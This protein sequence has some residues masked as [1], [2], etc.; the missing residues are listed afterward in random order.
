MSATFSQTLRS[1]ATERRRPSMGGIAL[2]V[3]LLGAWAFWFFRARVTVI[4][5]SETARL[6][7]DLAA[8]AVDAPVAGRIASS[9]LSIGLVV[10]TGDVLL[11]LD[12]EPEKRRLQE[13][14]TRLATIAPRIAAL[15]RVLAAEEQAIANDR[16]ATVIALGQARARR[17]EAEIAKRITTDEAERAA[18]LQ[19]SGAIAELE[20]LQ[21]EGEAERQRAAAQAMSLDVDLQQGNQKTRESQ[22]RA[23]IED[24]RV[25]LAA[26]E[27][28]AATETATIDRLRYE[29]DRRIIRAA[30]GGRIGDVAALR[31]GAYVKEGDKLGAIV[32]SGDIKIVAEFLPVAAMGRI[33][34]GQSARVRLDGYPWVEYGTLGA[35]VTG[36]GSELRAGR[37]RVELAVRPDRSSALPLEHGLPASAEVEVERV[38]PAALVARAVGKTLTERA[39]SS[40]TPSLP[41]DRRE[42]SP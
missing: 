13:E 1:L 12:S 19:A 7:V 20:A 9:R 28:Q 4:E 15:Q 2:T 27:G 3:I 32:P 36:V 11:E 38:T 33:R 21:K 8:H 39:T 37:I 31:P 6:E 35:T 42:A 23:R 22:A 10:A 16:G 25:E 26:L 24:M 18:K 30:I 14:T 5:T 17:E 41:T 29:I 34:V 40:P